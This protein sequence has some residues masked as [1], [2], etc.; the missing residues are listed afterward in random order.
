MPVSTIIELSSGE[1]DKPVENLGERQKGLRKRTVKH[2]DSTNNCRNDSAER[3]NLALSP[4]L[5][6]NCV[7]LGSL[8]SLLPGFKQFFQSQP[9]DR[10]GILPFGQAVLELL[11]SGDPPAL[12]SQSSGITGSC[13][14]AQGGMQWHHHST[15]QPQT[16]EPQVI[17]PLQ[18]LKGGGGGLT[19]LPQAGLKLLASSNPPALAFQSA[20]ITVGNGVSVTQ[21]GRLE[22][23]GSISAHCNLCL[24]GSIQPGFNVLARMVSI[25]WPCDQPPWPPKVLGLQ[26][27]AMICRLSLPNC[28][29]CKRKPLC[30]AYSYASD[31]QF[32]FTLYKQLFH[33]TNDLLTDKSRYSFIFE[34]EFLS[35][36]QAGVQCCDLG[37]L[38]PPPPGFNTWVYHHTWLTCEFLVET[39]VSPCWSGWSRIP[40]LRCSAPLSLP[41]CWDY[42]HEPSCLGH[43]LKILAKHSRARWSLALSPGWSAVVRSQLTATFTYQVQVI[44]LPQPFEYLGLQA[45]ATTPSYNFCIFSGRINLVPVTPSQV[46]A[47]VHSLSV[48][49]SQLTAISASGFKRFSCLSLPT[50]KQTS[51]AEPQKLTSSLSQ[52]ERATRLTALRSSNHHSPASAPGLGLQAPTTPGICFS[53]AGFHRVG[54]MKAHSVAQA[55]VQWHDLGS[56]QPLPPKFNQFSCL[57][58]LSVWNYRHPPPR[59]ANFCILSEDRVSPCWPSWSRTPDFSF[60]LFETVSLCHP[61]G[62]QWRNLGSLQPL[63]PRFKQFSCLNL[64]S[65]RDYRDRVLQCWPGWSQSPDLVI[66]RLSLQ[67]CWDYRYKKAEDRSF[68]KDQ[69]EMGSMLYRLVLDSWAQVILPPQPPKEEV[70]ISNISKNL[71][72]VDTNPHD[73]FERFKISV[74]EVSTDV[75]EIARE[76]EKKPE[77]T[78]EL[79]QSHD[80]A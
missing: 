39:G 58:L 67:K 26:A 7:N 78:I 64:L 56:L 10:D 11:T 13:S 31:F 59:P 65:S 44:L 71:E 37:S 22:F 74:K 16:P 72:E 63:P 34:T 48:V 1:L 46:D 36:A 60:S 5:E 2:V 21:A 73:D 42:R 19:M 55:G 54:Q 45:C 3:W 70:K 49:R 61:A 4:R 79:L 23:S 33:V 12:A 51:T 57:S 8:Q 27:R 41:K 66:H 52:A 14:A 80:Q 77:D 24:R 9:P 6:C 47:E 76:L 69:T 18:S 75:V 29:D 43:V 28:W 32:G 62:V 35:V 50:S 40:D 15:L 17:L 25:S 20:G 53:R 68:A 38:Q 30:L